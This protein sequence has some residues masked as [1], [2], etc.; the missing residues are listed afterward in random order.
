MRLSLVLLAAAAVFVAL[1]FAPESEAASAVTR[2]RPAANS[3]SEIKVG[4]AT[5]SR[6]RGSSTAT[7]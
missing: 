1:S 5:I 4:A 6:K 3:R 2:R 7:R